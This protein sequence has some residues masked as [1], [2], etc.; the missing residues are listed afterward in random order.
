L[1]PSKKEVFFGMKLSLR[2]PRSGIEGNLK[3]EKSVYHV[4]ALFGGRLR[5]RLLSQGTRLRAQRYH[6][7]LSQI[8]YG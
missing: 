6:L 5:A 8:S 3:E 1:T 2:R 4:S 7:S